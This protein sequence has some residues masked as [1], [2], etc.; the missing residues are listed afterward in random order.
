[1]ILLPSYA[2]AFCPGGSFASTIVQE[3]LVTTVWERTNGNALYCIEL[4]NSMHEKGVIRVYNG[5]C[6][7]AI[8]KCECKAEFKGTDCSLRRCPKP[9]SLALTRAQ[10]CV[11]LAAT[12]SS[13]HS[14]LVIAVA[15]RWFALSRRLRARPRSL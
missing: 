8:G 12:P 1:M 14:P 13:S 2:H 15:S 7:L 10:T 3:E 9:A 6:S 11:S 4:A 5:V